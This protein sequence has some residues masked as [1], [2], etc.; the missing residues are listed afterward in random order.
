MQTSNESSTAVPAARSATA[1]WPRML[2]AAPVLAAVALVLAAVALGGCGGGEVSDEL[3]AS[4]TPSG[5]SSSSS[6]PSVSGSAAPAAVVAAAKADTPVDPAIVAADN[7]FGL[8]LLNALIPGS[9]GN[10]AISPISIALALQILYNGAAGTTLQAMAQTLELGSLSTA[11]LNDDDA[12]LQASLMNPDPKVQL[13]IANSLW[14]HLSENPLLASF[15]K[16][17]ETYYGATLGDLSGA[18]D[19]VNAW[20]AGETHGLI[21]QILPKEPAGYYQQQVTAVIANVIYFKGEWSATFDPDQTAAAPFILSNG[22]EIPV[23]MMHQAGSYDYLEGTLRGT[24]FQAVRLPYGAGRLDMLI[25]LPDPGTPLATF[26]AAVTAQELNDWNGEFQN[27]YGSIALPRF[28][29]TYGQSLPEAL[30]AL[31][32]GIAFCP[33]VA[34]FSGL[35]SNPLQCI[36]DVEHKTMVEVDE[37]GTLAAGAT[38]VTIGPAVVVGPKFAMTMNHPFLY[39]IEDSKTRELLFVGILMDPS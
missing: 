10:V 23:E 3:N 32:M 14:T 8:N 4:G 27:E 20:V 18:P 33:N 39:A 6:A 26:A 30:T 35:A 15:T 28:T 21:T 5:S 36:A 17:N 25:V 31:G 19:D 38:A 11:A 13:T 37:S 12:A 24:P 7:G 29:A 22:N 1:V 9:T 16:T 34:D 2:A